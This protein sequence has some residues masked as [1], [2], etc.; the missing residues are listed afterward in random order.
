MTTKSTLAAVAIVGLTVKLV[1]D[2]IRHGND[3]LSVM[4]KEHDMPI[5]TPADGFRAGEKF[6]EI[7]R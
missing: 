2:R 4:N 7:Y 3:V 6:R 1:R 5:A